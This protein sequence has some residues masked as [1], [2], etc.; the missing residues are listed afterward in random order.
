[1]RYIIKHVREWLSGL[2][3]KRVKLTEMTVPKK[4]S[5][6][7]ETGINQEKRKSRI[8]LR[9]KRKPQ[10]AYHRRK[11]AN[12]LKRSRSKRAT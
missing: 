8:Y 1:M 6:Y 9:Q 5:G 11:K 2:F 4:Q 10:Y 7:G 12:A 3:G